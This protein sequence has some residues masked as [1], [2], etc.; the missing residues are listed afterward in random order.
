M[1]NRLFDAD[2][3]HLWH[4]W[5]HFS[6]GLEKQIFKWNKQGTS[7]SCERGTDLHCGKYQNLRCIKLSADTEW[8]CWW[9]CAKN[10]QLVLHSY[11]S[12]KFIKERTWLKQYGSELLAIV[13]SHL[14]SSSRLMCLSVTIPFTVKLVVFNEQTMTQVTSGRHRLGFEQLTE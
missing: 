9:C 7:K 6:L 8:E 1:I 13:T 11:N 12:A 4:C 2:N 10:T 3:N 14:Q 5:C